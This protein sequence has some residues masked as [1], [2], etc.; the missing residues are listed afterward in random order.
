MK[1]IVNEKGLTLIE[2]LLSL[3]IL[4]MT[5]T[6][7][8]TF[9]TNYTHQKE[10]QKNNVVMTNLAVKGIESI[11]MKLKEGY[12]DSVEYPVNEVEEVKHKEQVYSVTTSLETVDTRQVSYSRGELIKVITT[13][14]NGKRDR[15]VETYIYK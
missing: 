5:A 10:N 14:S 3:L 15:R 1:S 7:F 12:F 6:I 2:V 9:I 13:V 8:V 11:T 4:S